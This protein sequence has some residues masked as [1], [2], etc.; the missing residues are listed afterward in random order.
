[1]NRDYLNRPVRP[2]PDTEYRIEWA[3]DL[4]RDKTVEGGVNWNKVRQLMTLPLF[5]VLVWGGMDGVERAEQIAR[6][7]MA[8]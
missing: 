6:T 7:R 2:R 1:M 8:A 4:S 5:E 3:K